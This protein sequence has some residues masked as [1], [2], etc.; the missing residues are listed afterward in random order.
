MT[1]ISWC[2]RKN[3]KIYADIGPTVGV[4]NRVLYVL[5]I[6]RGPNHIRK[7]E[8]PPGMEALVSFGSTQDIGDAN[9]GLLLTL[10]TIRMLFRFRGFVDATDFIV[11]EKLAVPLILGAITATDIEAIYPRRK[12]V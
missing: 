11:C 8:L 2:S 12:M 6:G 4:M 5:D 3:Y 1:R 10:G 7:P 9:N